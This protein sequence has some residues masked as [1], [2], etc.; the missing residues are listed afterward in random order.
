MAP[1][2]P[3][4]VEMVVMPDH[5]TVAVKKLPRPSSMLS[6]PDPD[7][8][9]DCDGPDVLIA[10][11]VK[12]P[13]IVPSRPPTSM[14]GEPK[15]KESVLPSKTKSLRLVKSSWIRL[16]WAWEAPTSASA[17]ARVHVIRKSFR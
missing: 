8:A 4:G 1:N 14:D 10:P 2:P 9:A 11:I 15:L 16:A 3:K 13:L 17:P 12:A 7:T 5:A 6:V